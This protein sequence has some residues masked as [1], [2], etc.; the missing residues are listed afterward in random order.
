MRVVEIIWT[1]VRHDEHVPYKQ[2][3]TF[4]HD[5]SRLLQK[6]MQLQFQA[7]SSQTLP[8]RLLVKFPGD[9]MGVK[10]E[11]SLISTDYQPSAASIKL[12]CI[13]HISWA[14]T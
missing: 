5:C 1:E 4:D 9:F 12:L 13:K 8:Q 10:N 6:Y 7:V 2:L 14:V 11:H 3:W